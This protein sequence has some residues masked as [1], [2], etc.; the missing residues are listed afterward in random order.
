MSIFYIHGLHLCS[1]KT[2]KAGFYCLE[3]NK[4]SRL[5]IWGSFL[6]WSWC[7]WKYLEEFVKSG[8]ALATAW[9]CLRQLYLHLAPL[10]VGLPP[11]FS[12]LRVLVLGASFFACFV[13]LVWFFFFVYAS[14]KNKLARRFHGTLSYLYYLPLLETHIGTCAR[15]KS[16][17]TNV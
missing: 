14:I 1:S 13:I 15:R 2:E 9:R 3:K 11:S 4:Q 5:L 6:A 17:K 7:P 8:F 12:T 10:P 16:E